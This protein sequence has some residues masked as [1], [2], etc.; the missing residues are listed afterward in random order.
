MRKNATA[1]INAFKTNSA[2]DEGTIRTDGTTVWSYQMVIAKRRQDGSVE[3]IDVAKSPSRTTSSHIRACLVGFVGAQVV[4]V[5][6]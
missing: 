5:V 1:V 4:Q 6:S 3:I 2:C